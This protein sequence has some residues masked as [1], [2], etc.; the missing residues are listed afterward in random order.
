[1][2]KTLWLPAIALFSCFSYA[3]RDTVIIRPAAIDD[4][5]QNPDMESPPSRDSTDKRPTRR[6]SGPKL[7]PSSNFRRLQPNPIF[8]TLRSPIYAGIGTRSSQSPENSTGK[9]STL[10]CKRR[11]TRADVGHTANALLEQ[12]STSRV[13]PILRARRANKPSDKDGSIWQ[14]DFSDP[15]FLKY[16]S[17]LVAEAGRRYDG[18]PYLDSVDISS[19]GYWGEGWS[20]YMPASP[21]R[22]R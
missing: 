8:P 7:G 12:G 18:N 17:E 3:Q 1:V 15:L 2:K 22:R 19:V 21:T 13:V 20:P 4:V 5:L 11:G 9:L 6:W 16:W 10:L 14:P